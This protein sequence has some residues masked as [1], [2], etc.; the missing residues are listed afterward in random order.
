MH[1]HLKH[2][3]RR[4]KVYLAT[5]YHEVIKDI[6]GLKFLLKPLSKDL[7]KLCTKYFS[8]INKRVQLEFM[9]LQF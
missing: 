7:D 3:A 9:K 2:F 4:E 5:S 6:T 1:L 8:P